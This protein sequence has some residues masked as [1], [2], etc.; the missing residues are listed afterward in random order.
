MGIDMRLLKK[1][2]VQLGM[3]T[4]SYTIVAYMAVSDILLFH[5][6]AAGKDRAEDNSLQSCAS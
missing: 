1:V 2:D 4:R 3:R 6:Y 5:V